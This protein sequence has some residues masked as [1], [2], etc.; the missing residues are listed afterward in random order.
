MKKPW[1]YGSRRELEEVGAN[2]IAGDKDGLCRFIM[3]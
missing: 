1:G 2:L 3:G